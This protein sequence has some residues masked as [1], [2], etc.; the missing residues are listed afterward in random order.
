MH[1]PTERQQSRRPNRF[2]EDDVEPGAE[3]LRQKFCVGRGGL[4][5][6][7]V[8]NRGAVGT[9]NLE[10]SHFGHQAPGSRGEGF[11]VAQVGT[12]D[13]PERIKE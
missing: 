3:V 1:A 10:A 13:Q 11:S 12:G 8:W 5:R 9:A 2:R 4:Q 7:D 6:S